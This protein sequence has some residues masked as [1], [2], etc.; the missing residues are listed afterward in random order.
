MKEIWKKHKLSIAT[1]AFLALLLAMILFLAVPFIKKIKEK[2]DNVQKK[3][4]DNQIDRERIEKIPQMG[5]TQKVINEKRGEIDVIL[6]HEDEVEFI[7]KLEAL[8]DQTG[9]KM[10]LTVNEPKAGSP[11]VPKAKAIGEKKGILDSLS[12][13]KYVSIQINLEGDYLGLVDFLSKLEN[14]KYYVNVISLESK[15]NIEV[16]DGGAGDAM[17]RNG[18][19]FSAPGSVS[20]PKSVSEGEISKREKDV[21]S[22]TINI[23]VYTKE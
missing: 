5:D 17:P 7:K 3:I 19:I 6:N 21:L 12:Y 4:L 10:T 16:V 11:A 2:A 15:K 1:L 9:N 8:A 13:D 20:A 14:F 18:D 22:S 23:I